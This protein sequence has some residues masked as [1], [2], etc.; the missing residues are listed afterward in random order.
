MPKTTTKNQFPS[1]LFAFI[2]SLLQSDLLVIHSH[3]WP[4]AEI[5]THAHTASNDEHCALSPV[6]SRRWYST[7]RG[8][9]RRS[10]W[11][12]FC[13]NHV[14]CC[15]LT[16]RLTACNS[17]P[18]EVATR[19]ED[20]DHS[21]RAHIACSSSAHSPIVPSLPVFRCVSSICGRAAD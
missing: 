17:T 10:A 4:Q 7:C 15:R 21:Q 5:H 11:S 2:N 18:V 14:A 16:A 9:S 19:S 12:S 8:S 1:T 20:S 13:I 6:F 3:D